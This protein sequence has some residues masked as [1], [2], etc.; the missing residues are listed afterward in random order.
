MIHEECVTPLRQMF[1]E[2]KDSFVQL[3]VDSIN[4]DG[5]QYKNPNFS[6]KFFFFF[7]FFDTTDWTP[8]L[9]KLK[10]STSFDMGE[11]MIPP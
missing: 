3:G 11:I 9:W 8:I 5:E 4:L 1:Q 10:S 2:H 6:G 7:S